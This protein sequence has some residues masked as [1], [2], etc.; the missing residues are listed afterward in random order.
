MTRPIR[1]FQRMPAKRVLLTKYW[2]FHLFLQ[3]VFGKDKAFCT[4][5]ICSIVVRYFP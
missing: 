5:N 2:A 1:S 4:A 3:N